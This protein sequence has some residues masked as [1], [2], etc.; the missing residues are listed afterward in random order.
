MLD[1]RLHEQDAVNDRRGAADRR[2]LL[3]DLLEVVDLL[4]EIHFCI[5]R[6]DR[7][8]DVVVFLQNDFR[9]LAHCFNLY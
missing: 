6:L 5:R 9:L 4:A 7:H 3:D 2:G 8:E 1:L